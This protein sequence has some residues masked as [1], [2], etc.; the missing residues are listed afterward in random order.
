MR[1]H[2]RTA[3]PADRLWILWQAV[4]NARDADAAAA[5]IGTQEGGSAY[6]LASAF[7][8]MLGREVPV[9]AIDTF[10]GHPSEKISQNDGRRWFDRERPPEPVS[11]EDVVDYLSEF[12]LVSV[13]KGEFTAVAPELPDQRYGV[14]HVDVNLYESTL[15]ALR[16]F[17]PRLVRGG[18][19]V[20]DDYDSPTCPGIR[21]AAEDFLAERRGFHSWHP[22]THQLVLVRQD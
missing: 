13:H 9:V 14:V 11:F 6:F 17:A 8:T 7:R 1:G 12:E 21:R 18:I 20:I 15:D 16:Y 10:E 3:A 5:D 19:V 4:R 2:R 22:H